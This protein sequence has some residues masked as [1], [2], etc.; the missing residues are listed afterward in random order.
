[1][2]LKFHYDTDQTEYILL[3]IKIISTNGYIVEWHYMYFR[4][5]LGCKQAWVIIMNLDCVKI[6]KMY[7]FEE[8][9]SRTHCIVNNSIRVNL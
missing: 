3:L 6:K 9:I 7:A 8:A 5:M 2:L 1:M 4:W